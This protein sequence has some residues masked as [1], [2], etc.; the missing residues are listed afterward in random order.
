MEPDENAVRWAG[1]QLG[2]TAP[3]ACAQAVN[4][5]LGIRDVEY[6]GDL[7]LKNLLSTKR[8]Q[9]LALQDAVLRFLASLPN[10]EWTVVG[11]QFLLEAGGRWNA[12][13]V[14]SLLDKVMAQARDKT[15][16]LAEMC[17]IRSVSPAVRALASNAPVMISSALS[18]NTLFAAEDYFLYDETRRCV[19]CWADEW[20]ADQ[21]KEIWRFVPASPSFTDFYI[22]SVYSQ[23]YLVASDV[24]VSE[25]AE[26]YGEKRAFTWRAG[27]L[28]GDGGLWRL[29]PV[30]G[31]FAIYNLAQDTYLMSPPAS[32]SAF[33]RLVLTSSY[34][35]LDQCWN[36]CH[37]WSIKPAAPSL[38]ERGLDAFFAKDYT[39]AV[40]LLTNLLDNGKPSPVAS[41]K[42]YWYRM[43]ANLRLQ[44]KDQFHEDVELMNKLGDC[45]KYFL[46]VTKEVLGQDLTAVESAELAQRV[47][48]K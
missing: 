38:L 21:S 35:P 24:A 26:G 8:V 27:E 40:D 23:E 43:V 14:A 33:R 5:F 10:Q 19:F 41:M 7:L 48:Y 30:D 44:K 45:P 42:V 29:I 12:V 16:M 15:L 31:V 39:A 9:L 6:R 18:D 3:D 17:W 20:E 46:D 4:C 34:R 22:L 25:T 37:K 32:G 13:A 11:C 2:N 47:H 36:E 28:P 1:I